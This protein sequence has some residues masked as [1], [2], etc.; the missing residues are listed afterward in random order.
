M[1][2]L[3]V[4]ADDLG[5]F[6]SSL[7]AT[8]ELFAA[9]T[10]SSASAIVPA[11]WFPAVA[12][13]HA[14]HPEADI[15]LHLTLTSEWESYRWRPTTAAPSLADAHG[16]FHRRRADVLAAD[17]PLEAIHAELHNQIAIA[18]AAGMRPSHLDSHMFVLRQPRYLELFRRVAEESGIPALVARVDVNGESW[19]FPLFDTIHSL[20]LGEHEQRANAVLDY[21]RLLPD[22]IH[23][24]LIHPAK[25]TPELRAAASDWRARVADYEVFR[26]PA[27]RARI[28]GAGVELR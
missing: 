3:L 15:G 11:P 24:L 6:H 5:V 17:P 21:V 23:A 27:L 8:V 12:A 13:W 22:G 20:T 1:R 7:D 26:D 18:R 9:G 16:Y 4:H 28:L 19:P 25:D 14:A 2:R 10:V